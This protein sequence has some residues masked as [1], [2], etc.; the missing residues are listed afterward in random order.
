MMA[1][2]MNG[3]LWRAIYFFGQ[4]WM[5][6][7]ILPQM[8]SGE[9]M[10]ANCI[11]EPEGGTGKDINTKAEKIGDKW[12]INGHKWLISLF[13]GYPYFY[14]TFANTPEGITAFGVEH[15]NPGLVL[16]PMERMM[17]TVGPRHYNVYFKDCAVPENNILGVK[18]KGLDVAF[19]I[20]ALS[21][22]SIA[23]CC[24]GVA[25]KMFDV[26][27]DYAQKRYTFGKPLK[28][29]QAIQWSIA[30][31]GTEIHAGRLLYQQ[32][33]WMYDSGIPFDME[34]SMAKLF[35]EEMVTRVAEKALRMHGGVGYTAA[36]PIERHFRDCR[37][38][39][40][41]EGTAEIQ[42][43]VISRELLMGKK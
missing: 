35:T 37:S 8:A 2:A 4:E 39:H 12:V 27:V 40:F 36:Y 14:V 24:V 42:K 25:Q 20:L 30:E 28:S 23:A 9:I 13:P 22:V 7:Q 43:L 17:G 33:A 10:V 26:A 41:E 29:R 21:R 32:A 34:A 18:G 3:L 6:D 31:M 38:F 1:H 11:T 5:K 15:G 16:E 19:N